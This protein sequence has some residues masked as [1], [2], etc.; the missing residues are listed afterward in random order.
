M[1]V[2]LTDTSEAVARVV[3]EKAA[4]R[5]SG[6]SVDLIWIN[7]ENFR[8]MRQQA[9]LYGPFAADLPNFRYVDTKGKPT[10]LVDFTIPTEG[11]REPLGHGAVRALL[12]QRPRRLTRR[13]RWTRSGPSPRPTPAASPTRPRPTSPAPPSSSR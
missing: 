8:A 6:G 11:L 7:G 3:A 1:H 10:T 13:A 12:R 5:D 2:K 9:L 4:G